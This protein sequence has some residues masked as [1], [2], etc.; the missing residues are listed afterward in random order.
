MTPGQVDVETAVTREAA[1]RWTTHLHDAWN[2]EANPNGGYA[3]TPVLRAMQELAELPDPLAVTTHFLRPAHSGRTARVLAQ[4]RRRGRSMVTTSGTLVQDEKDRVV[5]MA[6]FCD[7]DDREVDPDAPPP[8]S[9]PDPE[10]CRDRFGLEQAMT[11]PLVDRIDVRIHPDQAD[12]GTSDRAVLTGWVRFTDERA[13]ETL[14]LPL[15]ADAFPPSAYVSEGP[16]GWIPTIDLT[17]HVRRRPVAGWLSG[18]F[19]SHVMSDDRVAEDGT[20]WDAAG[21]IVARTRQTAQ[22]LRRPGP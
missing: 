14:T 6:T 13:P 7:L 1:G 17:V 12:A 2:I 19:E 16:V 10:D 8:P 15:L 22:I 20:L 9:L 21:Q 5:T 18:R 11:I 3:A 4:V